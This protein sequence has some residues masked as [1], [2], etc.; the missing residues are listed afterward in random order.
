LL[1]AAAL[2]ALNAWSW[3]HGANI[4]FS[5][6]CVWWTSSKYEVVL[7]PPA[8]SQEFRAT[9]A[10]ARKDI[11]ESARGLKDECV[12]YCA[13]LPLDECGTTPASRGVCDL[14][15]D[16]KCIWHFPQR[17]DGREDILQVFPEIMVIRKSVAWT[18]W[19]AID[20]EPPGLSESE[21]S[22]KACCL[23]KDGRCRKPA[24]RC[25]EAMKV[26]RDGTWIDE[27]T[28]TWIDEPTPPPVAEDD[29]YHDG[30]DARPLS[31]TVPA[32]ARLPRLRDFE[33]VYDVDG[34]NVLAYL[35]VG[36][37]VACFVLRLV[38]GAGDT[39]A[40][41]VAAEAPPDT[42]FRAAAV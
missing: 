10:A 28:W 39:D 38:A 26:W 6:K 7:S 32:L 21:C 14:H 36:A 30:D 40:E 34:A 25:M 19:E 42:L 24:G 8:G 12:R 20:C 9:V 15:G 1:A 5:L 29:D 2:L 31:F 22:S 11:H 41:M 3:G 16:E 18:T 23:W 37:L 17:C 33:V 4:C 13:D 35:C 27:P